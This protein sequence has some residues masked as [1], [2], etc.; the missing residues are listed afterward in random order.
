MSN[1]DIFIDYYNKIDHHLKKSGNFDSFATFAQKIKLSN[2]G[3]V[4]RFSSDLISFGELRNAIVH[5][6]KIGNKTIAEPH[7]A[8]VSKIKELH[9]YITAPLKVY[10]EFQFDVLGALADDYIN[11][12]LVEMKANSFSQFPVYDE[13]G[14]VIELVNTNTVSRWLS[15]QLE[16]NGTLLMENVKVKD[17]IPEIEFKENYKFI[18]KEA[19]VYDAYELFINQIVKRERNL[20]VIFITET[21]SKNENLQG[22]ITIEDIANKV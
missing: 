17:L 12:I 11:K 19:T 14:K 2:N 13:N 1:S 5:N 21:G 3:A 15:A 16:E 8:T 4:R 9:Q 7:D 6:P 10:P 18:S 20:D 22:L